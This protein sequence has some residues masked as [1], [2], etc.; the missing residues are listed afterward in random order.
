M[1]RINFRLV[2]VATGLMALVVI[3]AMLW[4]K[5]ISD[6]AE[7]TGTDFITFYSAGRIMLSG[8]HANVYDPRIQVNEEEKI[9]GFPILPTD[10]NPF[11]HPPFILPILAAIAYLPYIW[12]FHAWAILL[13]I[14]YGVSALILLRV[15]P[16]LKGRNILFLGIV[17]FFP[18]F[19]SVLDGQDTA[20]LLLGASLWLYG[21]LGGDDRLAG[22]GLALT[23]IRPHIALLLALPFLFKRRRVWWW[24]LLGVAFLAAISLMLVGIKGVENFLNI[25]SI[26]AGGVGYKINEQSMVN[27]LGLLRRLVPGISPNGARL[28][29]WIVYACS[30]VFLCVVWRRSERIEEKHIGLAVL[31]ALMAA[32]HLHYHDMAMLLIPIACILSLVGKLKILDGKIT[33]LFPLVISW[34]LV[35]SN[36]L[37][38]LKFNLPTILGAVLLIALW[39]PEKLFSG[40]GE[41]I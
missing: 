30:I 20:L 28:A 21:L 3:Y 33:S 18:A 1:K 35:A 23:T 31:V 22:L 7:R 14:L 4:M 15:I 12:A 2:F 25:L 37:P 19:V 29:S 39:Y 17:L 32:P 11:V 16:Q 13:Y 8:E 36:P 10:L 5:M 27:F 38:L 6:S 26:S 40:H 24:F 41:T 9:L 34:L